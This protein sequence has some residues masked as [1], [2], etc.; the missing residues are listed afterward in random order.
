M[1]I[2]LDKTR[3]RI[4]CPKCQ[5]PSRPFFRQ[6]KDRDVLVCGGCKSN[7]QLVD[8]LGSYRKS[9]RRVRRALEELTSSLKNL[10]INIRL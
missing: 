3:I 7:I 2:D 4:E 8:H 1:N 6:V 10:T 5:F 9:E